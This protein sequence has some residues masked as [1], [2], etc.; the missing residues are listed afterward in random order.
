MGSARRP[1]VP[2][3]QSPGVHGDFREN[4]TAPGYYD[5]A[6]SLLVSGRCPCGSGGERTNR[7]AARFAG[8]RPHPAN[9]RFQIDVTD[10]G[11][12]EQW[13]R[14]DFDRS[15]W[16]RAVVPKAWDLSDEALWGYEGI[17][18]YTAI[19]PGTPARTNHVQRLKFGRVNYHSKVWLNDEPLGENIKH[20]RREKAIV[21]V[22]L[23]M[24][25]QASRIPATQAAVRNPPNLYESRS[26]AMLRIGFR[27]AP[28]RRPRTSRAFRGLRRLEDRSETRA[29]A[30]QG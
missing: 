29:L 1:P 16:S 9:W 8:N 27:R 23:E 7:A 2:A 6:C 25:D 10:I 19:I 11:G 28:R 20:N 21:N 4:P 14:R 5:N 30:G 18:W 24:I 12:K 15:Q 3:F 22:V 26:C 13:Y 17:G